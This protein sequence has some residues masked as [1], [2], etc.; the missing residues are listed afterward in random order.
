MNLKK[1]WHVLLLASLA[2]ALSAPAALAWPN[3][4]SGRQPSFQGPA[5]RGPAYGFNHQRPAWN[6]GR[7]NG[8]NQH[9]SW[10][11]GNAYG[12]NHRNQR[13]HHNAYGWNRRNQWGQPNHSDGRWQHPG[14][15]NPAMGHPYQARHPYAPIS[16]PGPR[17]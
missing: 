13:Q 16:A 17:W 1:W 7:V 12:W 9:N 8:L 11:R 14:Y 15:G 5:P 4:P 6:H 2:V 10:N 3:R